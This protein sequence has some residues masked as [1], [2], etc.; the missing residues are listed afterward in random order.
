LAEPE[1]IV[2]QEGDTFAVSL[3]TSYGDYTHTME[4]TLEIPSILGEDGYTYKYICEGQTITF[5]GKDYNAIGKYVV[6]ETKNM[7]G[8][9]STSYLV[10]DYLQREIIDLYDTICY[11]ALP[12]KFYEQECPNAGQYEYIIKAKGGCDS[13]VYR[14]N[15]NVYEALE[16]TLNDLP[17]ICMGDPSFDVNYN[18]LDGDVTKY[19][20]AFSA[21]AKKAGFVDTE[22]AVQSNAQWLTI[23]LPQDV[24]PNIYTADIYFENHDCDVVKIPLTFSVLYSSEII[25]QRW[26]DVIAVRQFAYDYYEGFSTYQWYRNGQPIAGANQSIYYN[27][28]GLH[29]SVYQVELTRSVDGVK[30]FS[31]Q[32]IP[33]EEPSTSTLVVQPTMLRPKGIVRVSAPESGTM[34]IINN[35]GSSTDNVNINQGENSVVVPSASGLYMMLLT[36]PTG[37]KYVQKII[38][39]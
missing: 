17:E 14:M 39:Y 23:D 5:E 27:P 3:T 4:Y 28:D 13:V 10:I 37:N 2:P 35:M 30:T 22:E 7:Y 19:S 9:D 8:C 12:Y 18:I 11:T 16:I 31:C 20:I 15:L 25:T 1:L 32:F 33:T 29:G 21:D 6:N 34:L 38:V 26:N 24:M 36:A